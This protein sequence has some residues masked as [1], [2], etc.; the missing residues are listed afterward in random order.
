MLTVVLLKKSTVQQKLHIPRGDK[1]Q[2]P[3]EPD[4]K[5]QNFGLLE[6]WNVL[7]ILSFY[8]AKNFF[9]LYALES[10]ISIL[11]VG[12]FYNARIDSSHVSSV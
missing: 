2:R 11:W 9:P 8:A 3:S 5:H 12:F 6:F 10:G 4:Y 1:L 7:F